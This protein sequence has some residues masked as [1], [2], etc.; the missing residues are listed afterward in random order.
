MFP[1]IIEYNLVLTLDKAN[2]E[3]DEEEIKQWLDNKIKEIMKPTNSIYEEA[4][5]IKSSRVI[6]LEKH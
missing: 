5:Q 6:I 1:K 2:R 3:T 4:I